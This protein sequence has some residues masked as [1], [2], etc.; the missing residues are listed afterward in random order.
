MTQLERFQKSIAQSKFDAA[1][2]S[3]EINIRYLCDINY[4]DGYLL[5]SANRAYLLAD[6]RYIEAAKSGA[7]GFEVIMPPYTMTDCLAELAA[8]N[9]FASIAI[10]ECEVSCSEFEKLMSAMPKEVSLVH[11]A[12]EILKCQRTV[13]LEY[14]L[15][16]I[17]AAQEITDKAFSHILS[18]LSY[19]MTEKDV[20]LELE[21]FM[22]RNGAE[23]TAFDTIA[24]S[25]P[26]SSLPHGVPS[27]V[28]L[29]R[30][31]LT[32]DFGAKYQGYCSDMTRTVAIGRLSDEEEYVYNTV[33]RAQATALDGL[34]E[35]ILCRDADALARDVIT[36]AGFG[37]AFG[38]SLG[39]GV[40]MFIHESP[41]F[42]PRAQ[43]DA[44]LC[45]GN[46]VTV[47]PGIYLEGRFGC[48]IE[49]M[50]ALDNNGN[51][52]NFTKSPKKLIR[53]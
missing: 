35:G 52:V 15:E 28:P 34:Y 11:G 1:I 45:R 18:V 12:S 42:A 5:I 21:Y 19:S 41:R 8:Q 49:D 53:I 30:G 26:A 51:I 46:V 13:K 25:G 7:K 36:N 23:A 38:H 31:L 48:R 33:L 4:T 39:H 50:I 40:G 29:R 2:I 20:A 27:D 37:A 17:A 32:M 6:F 47:E 14:E 9:K 10:E 43:E 44:R 3:S 16:R 24:V 22:R